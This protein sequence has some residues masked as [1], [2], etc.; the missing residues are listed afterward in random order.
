MIMKIMLAPRHYMASNVSLFVL[1]L[2]RTVTGF[3]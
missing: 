3:W 2:M 1:L